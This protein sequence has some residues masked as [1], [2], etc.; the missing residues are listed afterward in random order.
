MVYEFAGTAAHAAGNPWEGCSAL[1][2]AELMNIGVQFLREHMEPKSS[3]H[4]SIADA[5]G[6]SVV[7]QP[8][9]KLI[10]GLA[11]PSA[12]PRPCWPGSMTSPRARPS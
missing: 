3:I 12:R 8:T 2:G 9:A 5:G 1:D 11:E 7:V 10:Y 4:Y 6:I